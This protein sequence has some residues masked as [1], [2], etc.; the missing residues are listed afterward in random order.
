MRNAETLIAELD[1]V[2][3]KS[4]PAWRASVLR[5]ITDL[6]VDGASG[7]GHEHVAI[8]DAVLSRLAETVEQPSLA[9]LSGRL[10]AIENA[11]A[12]TVGRLSQYDNIAV[13]GPVL[14][15][16]SV[17]TEADIA[18]VARDR[19]PAH[20][21]A[22]AGRSQIAVGISDILIERGDAQVVR[23]VIA[24]HGASVSEVGFVKLINEAKRDK[25]LAAQIAERTDVPD[26]LRSFLSLSLN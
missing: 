18:L 11:P 2:L 19:G 9:E 15:R 20:L 8:Y 13:A 24:N 21:L 17:L 14:E 26:E 16:S 5:Q 6:F 23:K 3:V 4:T 10:A 7:Y 25:T 12:A 1:I 22:I